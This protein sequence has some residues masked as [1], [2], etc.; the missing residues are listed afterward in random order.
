MNVP[1]LR[2]YIIYFNDIKVY[3]GINP[4]GLFRTPASG[5]HERRPFIKGRPIPIRFTTGPCWEDSSGNSISP[6]LSIFIP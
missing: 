2:L 3:I 4:S 6:Y 1:F 5:S